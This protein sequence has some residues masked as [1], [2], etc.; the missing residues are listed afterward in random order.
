LTVAVLTCRAELAA[1]NIR[2]LHAI[3]AEPGK[4]FDND[5]QCQR[6]SIMKQA[7]D[8]KVGSR[9][10]VRNLDPTVCLSGLRG[11]TSLTDPKHKSFCCVYSRFL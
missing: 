5:D 10:H 6:W 11:E 4:A 2:R 9:Q 1:N 7:L 8:S 3:S